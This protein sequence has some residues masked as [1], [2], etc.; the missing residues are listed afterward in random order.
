MP[1]MAMWG[2][3]SDQGPVS[4]TVLLAFEQ[5]LAGVAGKAGGWHS[6]LGEPS[7]YA[8]WHPL[9]P[10]EQIKASRKASSQEAQAS[11]CC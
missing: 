3:D 7:R 8:D 2:R 10:K 5:T 9:V 1:K 4:A 6:E 11:E